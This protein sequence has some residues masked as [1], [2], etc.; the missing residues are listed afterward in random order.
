MYQNSAAA[1]A[2]CFLLPVDRMFGVHRFAPGPAFGRPPF[3][4]PVSAILHEIHEFRVRHCR[5]RNPK[6]LYKNLVSPLL[7]IKNEGH[8]RPAT[9]QKPSTGNLAIAKA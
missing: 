1:S 2:R 4:P 6:R 8:V 3:A 7:V 9:Q 5:P